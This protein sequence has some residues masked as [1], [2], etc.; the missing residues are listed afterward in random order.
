MTNLRISAVL[1]QVFEKALDEPKYSS[2]YAQLCHRLCEDAPNFEPPTS[3]ITV[4]QD[5]FIE[6][7][8]RN[9]VVYK[10]GSYRSLEVLESTWNS[11]MLSQGLGIIENQYFFDYGA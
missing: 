2:L 5:F 4:S 9:E 11:S 10:Q 6:T 8:S 1:F 3:N 7:C